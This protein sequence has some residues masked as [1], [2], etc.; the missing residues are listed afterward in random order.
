MEEPIKFNLWGRIIPDKRM[1]ALDFVRKQAVFSSEIELRKAVMSA[2]Q[3]NEQMQISA[4]FGLRAVTD[5]ANSLS[6]IFTD[7][8]LCQESYWPAGART[9]CAA[10]NLHFGGCL[11]CHICSGFYRA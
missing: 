11:G 7:L 3:A 1:D 4:A 6:M 5:L 2:I 9:Y 8:T 10:H